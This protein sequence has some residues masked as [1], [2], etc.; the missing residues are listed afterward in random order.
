M[1]SDVDATFPADNEK[2]SKATMRAQFLVIK[3]ELEDL[4]SK[5][6]LPW[7]IARGELSV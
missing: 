2:V 7:K 6:R 4:Q 5:V 3:N 1:A